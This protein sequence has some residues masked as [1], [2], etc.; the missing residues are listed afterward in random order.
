MRKFSFLLLSLLLLT[1]A[2]QAISVGVS[3]TPQKATKSPLT[4]I[5]ASETPAEMSYR[6]IGTCAREW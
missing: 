4:T 2:C 6:T 1:V 3:L 5:P